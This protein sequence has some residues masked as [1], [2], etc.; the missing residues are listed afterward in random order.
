MHIILMYRIYDYRYAHIIEYMYSLSVCEDFKHICTYTFMLN[1]F[2]S[3]PPPQQQR[4]QR[5][6]QCT[7]RAFGIILIIKWLIKCYST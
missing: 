5:L 6:A 1:A 2:C 4:Q 7:R 3:E